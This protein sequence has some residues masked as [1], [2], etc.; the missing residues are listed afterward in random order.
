MPQLYIFGLA[1]VIAENVMF[2]P[3]SLV[4]N[5]AYF[6]RGVHLPTCNSVATTSCARRKIITRRE[7]TICGNVV[8]RPNFDWP[9]PSGRRSSLRS[10][11]GINYNSAEPAAFYPVSH[12]AAVVSRGVERSKARV[13]KPQPA[14]ATG[15]ILTCLIARLI[16]Y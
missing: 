9:H 14:A 10:F 11:S 16:V 12:K 8:S 1:V 4:A 2:P 3:Q 6:C 5:D 13:E 7:K 15:G